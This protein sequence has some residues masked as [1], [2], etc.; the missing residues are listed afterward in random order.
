[1]ENVIVRR[2]G[3]SYELKLLDMFNW[4]RATRQ[5]RDDDI[6][7]SIRIFYDAIGGSKR[8]SKHPKVIKQIICGLKRTLIL[9]RFKTAS[10]L[11]VMLETTSWN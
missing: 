7:D 10:A 1:M 8:Y 4:G 2:L 6:C 5:N 9:K 3:L 11:R